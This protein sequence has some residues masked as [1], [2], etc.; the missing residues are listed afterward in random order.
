MRTQRRV[1]ECL[2]LFGFDLDQCSKAI[3]YSLCTLFGLP[4]ERG[5]LLNAGVRLI[6]R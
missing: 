6:D 4:D 1:G 3:F 2:T 5:S